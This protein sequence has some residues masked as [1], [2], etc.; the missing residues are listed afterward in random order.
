MK[1]PIPKIPS[2]NS[3]EKRSVYDYKVNQVTKIFS[4]SIKKWV[5]Y[6]NIISKFLKQIQFV[7][8]KTLIT[9][10]RALALVVS[11]IKN[12]Y[13]VTVITQNCKH[14]DVTIRGAFGFN[15][16]ILLCKNLVIR[17]HKGKCMFAKRPMNLTTVT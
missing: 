8:I 15:G 6:L 7:V 10:S 14:K 16:Y 4:S 12:K 2:P 3:F 13:C 1:Y 17:F 11:T 5:Y 9:Y